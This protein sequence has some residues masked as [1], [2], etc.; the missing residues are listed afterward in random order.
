MPE[1]S[2]RGVHGLRNHPRRDPRQ[3]RARHAQPAAGAERAELDARRRA[4]PG[5]RRLRGR[6]GDRLHRH[7]RL[8]R[9]PSRPAPTSR[10]CR[11][12]ATRRPISRTSSPPGIASASA[13]SRSIAAVAGFALGGGCELAMMC[14]IIIAADTAQIRPARDQARRHA[15]HRRHAAADPRRRQGEGDGDVPHR[16][17]DGRRGGRALGPRRARRAGRRAARRG[18]EGGRHDRRPCRCRSS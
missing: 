5:A 10:R 7:H 3:G 18:A 1:H 15:G 9:R 12:R 6:P 13:A 17:H 2:R 16:P 4:E 8:A 14:D 11:T